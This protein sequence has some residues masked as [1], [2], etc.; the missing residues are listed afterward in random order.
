MRVM[1]LHLRKLVVLFVLISAAYAIACGNES[2]PTSEGASEE[3][4]PVAE[5]TLNAID[6][7]VELSAWT[8]PSSSF[9]FDQFTDVGWKQHQI[10]DVATLDEA[11]EARYG[12]YNRKDIE[13]RTYPSHE[14]AMNVGAESAQEAVDKVVHDGSGFRSR[15]VYGGYLVV[16]NLVMLCEVSTQ[17]C[18]DLVEAV[19]MAQIQ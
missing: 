8:R 10:Y 3:V 15:R 6:G 14:L 13:I 18:L 19:E 16:G 1:T 12:F 7:R 17:D 11:I 4:D 5:T 2:P 9:S